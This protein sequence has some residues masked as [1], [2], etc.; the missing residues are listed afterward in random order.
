MGDIKTYTVE[1]PFLHIECG[2]GEAPFW[3]EK[4][5]TLRFVDI[6]KQKVHTIGPYH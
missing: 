2:L 3:E 4:S 5:N 6:V 1:E